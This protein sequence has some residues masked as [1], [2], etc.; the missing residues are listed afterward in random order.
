M[1]VRLHHPL[2]ILVGLYTSHVRCSLTVTEFDQVEKGGWFKVWLANET[3]ECSDLGKYGM[4]VVGS[5]RLNDSQG[6]G[7]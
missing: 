3:L 5:C 7:L 4:M 6:K 2:E 1:L